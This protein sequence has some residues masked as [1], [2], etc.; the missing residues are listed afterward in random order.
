MRRREFLSLVGSAAAAWPVGTEAQ[1]AS[2]PTIAFVDARSADA[3]AGRLRG[4]RQGLK[5]TGY[6]EGENVSIIYRF[7]ENQ[8]DQ[9]A[10]VA[11]DLRRRQVAVV[12]TAG[13]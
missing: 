11:A 5:K 6:V 8:I 13:D 12:A 9:V 4:F 3:I 2:L 1:P 7:T 10:P